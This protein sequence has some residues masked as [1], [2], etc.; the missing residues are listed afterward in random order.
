VSRA[1]AGVI[2]AR[3]AGDPVRARRL[4]MAVLL[5]L[6]AYGRVSCG[7]LE[8][9]SGPQARCRLRVADVGI[10][11]RAIRKQLPGQRASA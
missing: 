5:G 2:R 7:E 8:F 10:E 1:M 6:A 3:E 11:V 9:D 4:R